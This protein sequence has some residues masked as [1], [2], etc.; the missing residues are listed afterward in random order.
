MDMQSKDPLVL[1]TGT[2]V[3]SR[4]AMASHKWLLV[5]LA[6]NLVLLG[7]FFT[8]FFTSN[9]CA[10]SVSTPS[11]APVVAPQSKISIPNSFAPNDVVVYFDAGCMF[12][13]RSFPRDTCFW[14]NES[15]NKLTCVGGVPSAITYGGDSQCSGE[16]RVVGTANNDAGCRPIQTEK[17]LYYINAQC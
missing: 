9:S 2:V 12:A 6:L 17:G 16:G 4:C 11:T 14:E 8:S 5:S 3:K 1:T 15:F 7:S 13:A 10:A